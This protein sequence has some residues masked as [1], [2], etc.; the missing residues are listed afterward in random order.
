MYAGVCRNR[1]EISRQGDIDLSRAIGALYNW[2][3]AKG[4]VLA[5]AG[6][7]VEYLGTQPDVRY[8]SVGLCMLAQPGHGSAQ[9]SI[10]KMSESELCTLV[11]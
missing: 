10:L 1:G 3:I 6:W 5:Q 9:T 11:T 2:P 8:V 4:R 7:T